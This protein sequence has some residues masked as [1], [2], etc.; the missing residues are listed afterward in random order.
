MRLVASNMGVDIDRRDSGNRANFNRV[1]VITR[2][3][4]NAVQNDG[5]LAAYEANRDVL[6]GTEWLTAR[7]ERVCKICQALDGQQWAFDDPQRQQPPYDSHPNCRC[8]IIPWIRD[9][10]QAVNTGN[11][12][13]TFRDFLLG[14]GVGYLLEDFLRGRRLDSAR[15]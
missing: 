8:A 10:W 6:Q 1:Q 12:K 7:D 9:D 11:P 4:F 3:V 14:V 15:V 13:N 5:A 2:T